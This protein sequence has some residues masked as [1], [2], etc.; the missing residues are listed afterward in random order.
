MDKGAYDSMVLKRASIAYSWEKRIS[1]YTID[2]VNEE[3]FPENKTSES[4]VVENQGPI[5]RNFLITHIVLF[6]DM[7]SFA[8]GLKSIKEACD[9]ADCKVE[10]E[11]PDNGLAVVFYQHGTQKLSG[12]AQKGKENQS[13]A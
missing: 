6:K 5:R 7:E 2:D 9:K 1:K 3:A 4:Y 8:T 10:F 12:I 13:I 11:T